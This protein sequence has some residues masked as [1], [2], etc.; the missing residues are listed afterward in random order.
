MRYF[1][2]QTRC[3]K[4]FESVW[5]LVLCDEKK[6]KKNLRLQIFYFSLVFVRS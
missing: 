3:K 5:L 4:N 6:T 2:K 1:K